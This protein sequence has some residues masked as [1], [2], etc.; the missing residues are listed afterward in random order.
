MK[1]IIIIEDEKS[2]SDYIEEGILSVFQTHEVEIHHTYD[3]I[4]ELIKSIKEKKASDWINELCENFDLIIIDVALTGGYDE[5]G[6]KLFQQIE[7]NDNNF[8]ILSK[9]AKTDFIT[10]VDI[11]RNFINKNINKAWRLKTPI[12]RLVKKN[13][14]QEEKR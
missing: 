7:T 4:D 1:K 12:N 10:Q 8:I 6:L 13:L 11:G 14:R 5:Y 9:W 2:P 3:K